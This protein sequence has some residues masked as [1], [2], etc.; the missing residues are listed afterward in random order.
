MRKSEESLY[1]CKLKP[2]VQTSA[3]CIMV[4]NLKIYAEYT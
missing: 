3:Y 1:I 2:D 4:K